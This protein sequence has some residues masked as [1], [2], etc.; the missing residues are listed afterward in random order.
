MYDEVILNPGEQYTL[1]PDTHHWFKAWTRVIWDVT[2]VA[3]LLNEKDR[4][5]LSRVINTH[6]PN[7]DN[8]YNI[9]NSN[10]YM[11]YVYFIKRD[12]L[13]TDLINKLLK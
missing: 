2:A 5:M 4:F 7:Y 12:E 6:I 11:N 1:Y 10:S 9:A 8:Q 3:W 13:M